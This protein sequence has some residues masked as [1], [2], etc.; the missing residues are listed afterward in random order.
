MFAKLRDE[1]PLHIAELCDRVWQQQDLFVRWPREGS[2][3]IPDA[4]RIPYHTYSAE[5]RK[6]LR[7]ANVV[8]DARSNG[9]AIAAFLV[10]GGE[11]PARIAP[12]RAWSIHHIYDGQFP[13][14]PNTSSIR[15]VKDGRYFT[16]SAGLVAIH[17]IADALA[18]EVPYFAWLLRQEAYKR[19]GFDPDG[20]FSGIR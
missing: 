15:A 1:L 5:H 11:R 13:M 3:F 8:V 9:P 20:I 6:L 17:P 2:L 19:F 12:G 18:D 16:H 7:S 4:I 14:P 10:A